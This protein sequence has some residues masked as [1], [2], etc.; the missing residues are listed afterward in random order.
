M[1]AMSGASPRHGDIVNNLAAILRAQV[2]GRCRYYITDLRLFIPATGLFTYP[3]LLVICGEIL[4]SG[5]R[6]DI[7]TNPSVIAEVLSKSTA[8]YDRGERF[9]HYRSIPSLSD[10]LI[11]AQDSTHIEHHAKQADGSWLLR[12]YSSIEDVV[13]IASISAEVSLGVA[14]EDVDFSAPQN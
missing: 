11:I 8:N 5:D 1:F 10:Y 13:R 3:D 14:Y 12:E 7:V 4:Y 6:K 2:R 9:L